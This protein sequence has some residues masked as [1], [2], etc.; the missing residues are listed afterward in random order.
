[1][2]DRWQEDPPQYAFDFSGQNVTF[3]DLM[4]NEVTF[5]QDCDGRTIIP[6]TQ[7]PLFI[8][9]MPG[10]ETQL[11]NAITHFDYPVGTS[12][13]IMDADFHNGRYDCHR[14]G[15]LV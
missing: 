4:E 15:F 3:I 14:G 2:L 10:T 1:M 7:F 12:I 8:K 9:G 11:S 6:I 5:P 13:T